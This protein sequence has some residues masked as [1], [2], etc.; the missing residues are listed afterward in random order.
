MKKTIAVLLVSV[1]MAVP[2]SVEAQQ[3]RKCFFESDC[4]K[5]FACITAKGAVNGSCQPRSTITSEQKQTLVPN[6]IIDET[7]TCTFNTDCPDGGQCVK[8]PGA[9]RGTCQ[10]SGYGTVP[11]H[12]TILD[13]K[14]TCFFD[15]DCRP[16]QRCSKPQGSFKGMCEDDFYDTQDDSNDPRKL[17]QNQFRT[18]H[19]KCLMD[20]DC[21]IREVCLQ[22]TRAVFGEC[23]PKTIVDALPTPTPT[24]TKD[25]F[26]F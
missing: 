19:R 7:G 2:A 6:S 3:G 15:Q 24:P 17:L 22:R 14:R 8:Q 16:G 10:G 4:E 21:G 20:G 12:T 25:P 11:L 23:T 1:W 13:Q 9:L 5:G 26:Q 18:S